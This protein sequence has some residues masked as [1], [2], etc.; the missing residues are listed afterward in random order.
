MSFSISLSLTLLISRTFFLTFSLSQSLVLCLSCFLSLTL[1]YTLSLSY[2]HKLSLPYAI[3]PFLLTIF[4]HTLSYSLFLFLSRTLSPSVSLSLLPSLVIIIFQNPD[5]GLQ[6]KIS[7]L[8]TALGVT[9]IITI[10]VMYS[11]TLCCPAYM[12]NKFTSGT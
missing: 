9:Q 11:V 6:N 5:A 7:C 12:F 2:S 1:P 8:A 3:L 10:I 4:S